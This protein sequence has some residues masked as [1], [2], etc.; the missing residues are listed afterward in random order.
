MQVERSFLPI[1]EQLLDPHAPPVQSHDLEA[2]GKIGRQAP[3]LLLPFGPTVNHIYRPEVMVFRDRDSV[4]RVAAPFL[5]IQ[6]AALLPRLGTDLFGIG[7][8]G[9]CLFGIGLPIP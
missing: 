2:S 6:C 8:R 1:P 4:Q 5:R 7:L 3:G 9:I